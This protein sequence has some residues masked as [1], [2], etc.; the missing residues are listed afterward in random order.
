MVLFSL[1]TA[2]IAPLRVPA[3]QATKSERVREREPYEHI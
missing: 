1:F 2:K 3:L